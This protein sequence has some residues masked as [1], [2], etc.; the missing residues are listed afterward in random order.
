MTLLAARLLALLLLFGHRLAQGAHTVA[1]GF[2]GFG[3]AV[4]RFGVIALA[5]GIFCP[6]HGATGLIE[7]V[8]RR[9]ALGSAQG[10][11]VPLALQLIAQGLLTLRQITGAA[12]AVL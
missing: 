8:P 4:D 2:H 7:R 9:F 12:L 6:F 1:Q 11:A 3:L 10:Q 5:Q